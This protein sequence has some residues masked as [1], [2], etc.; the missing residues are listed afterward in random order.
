MLHLDDEYIREHL[1]DGMFGLEKES[2]RVLSDGSFSHTPHPAP[3]DKHIVR[4]FCE[5]QI[6]INTDP[7][8]SA[9]EAIKALTECEGKL[10]DKLVR[11]EEPEYLWPFS[12]PPYIKGEEDIPIAVYTGDE[13]W[14]T[15]YR[16]HLSGVYGRYK[17]TFSGIHVNYSFSEELLRH[18]ASLT[19][20]GAG[21]EITDEA[22]R[23]FKDDFYVSLTE[24]MSYCGW[25]LVALTAASP[26][27]DGSF[28]GGNFDDTVNTGMASVR[29]SESGYWNF[30]DPVFDYSSLE[31][32]ADSIEE[33][34]ASGRLNASSELYYPVRLKPNTAYSVDN[35]REY[36]AGHIELRMY[37]LNPF[38]PEGLDIRD[39][40]FAQYLLVF[41]ASLGR[42]NLTEDEQRKAV[43]NFK[44][45]AHFN[46]DS[47]E[48]VGKCGFAENIRDAAHGLMESMS[49]FYASMLDDDSHFKD[50]IAF[51]SSKIDDDRNRYANRVL[52]EYGQDFV[53]KGLELAKSR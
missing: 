12:N 50:I 49:S 7:Y 19:F 46:L 35:L 10:K 18:E 28:T 27:M 15:E 5:N 20:D 25:L 22:Y 14:K 42:V 1:L 47:I 39:V 24:K 8:D 44:N 2:L 38:V 40:E 36:G 30:F 51:E 21:K 4:D 37:D 52:E 33:Y 11:M 26:V 45:A 53:R 43:Q 32:Y 29:C 34:V 6:E 3:N 31:K 23:Q 41:L 13:A 16:K 9:E 17:M 48:I